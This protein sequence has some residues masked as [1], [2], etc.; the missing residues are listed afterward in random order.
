VLSRHIQTGNSTEIVGQ[1]QRKNNDGEAA[2]V[3]NSMGL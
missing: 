3:Y 1:N 2:A